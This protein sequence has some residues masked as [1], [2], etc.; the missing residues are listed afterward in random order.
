MIIKVTANGKF[1]NKTK[2]V[3]CLEGVGEF[4]QEWMF[5]ALQYPILGQCMSDLKRI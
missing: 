4:S 1:H 3:G 2:S 5:T